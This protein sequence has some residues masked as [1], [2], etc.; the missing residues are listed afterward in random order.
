MIQRKKQIEKLLE[1]IQSLKRKIFFG[2][3]CNLKNGHIPSSQWFVLQHL[4]KSEGTTLKELAQSLSM[5][6]S[7]ATQ[8]VE[9]LV[10]KGYILR[11]IGTNDRR[12]L[13]LMLSDK[14]RKHIEE[15]RNKRIQGMEHVFDVLN[16]EEFKSYCRLC[17]KVAESLAVKEKQ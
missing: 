1:N 5:T 17:S 12:E 13:K 15:L 2:V 10:Q 11:K 16:D 7:A 3:A 14:S 9:A 4:N 6:S 8:L